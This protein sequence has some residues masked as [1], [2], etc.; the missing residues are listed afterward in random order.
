MIEMH[1]IRTHD[2]LGTEVVTTIFN[3]DDY[4]KVWEDMVEVFANDPEVELERWKVT[5]AYN[6]D[7]VFDYWDRNRAVWREV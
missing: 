1:A 5:C 7:L 6:N 4:D 3:H 2:T